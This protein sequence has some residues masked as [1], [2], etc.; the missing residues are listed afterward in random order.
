MEDELKLKSYNYDN[1]EKEMGD[2]EACYQQKIIS[3]KEI[4]KK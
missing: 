3:L 4:Q 2:M 1:M